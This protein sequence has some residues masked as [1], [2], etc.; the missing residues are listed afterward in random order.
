MAFAVTLS[1]GPVLP[2]ALDLPQVCVG[3]CEVRKV[4]AASFSIAT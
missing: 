2:P 1:R 4:V 3:L